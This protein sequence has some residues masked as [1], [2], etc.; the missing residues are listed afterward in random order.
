[1]KKR[2]ID[3][4]YPLKTMDIEREDS[5]ALYCFCIIVGVAI[6]VGLVIGKFIFSV[7]F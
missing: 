4:G 3:R 6:A 2:Y 1:M 7:I 5:K